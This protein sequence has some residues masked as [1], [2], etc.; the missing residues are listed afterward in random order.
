MRKKVTSL[1]FSIIILIS[2]CSPRYIDQPPA[3]DSL[4][5]AINVKDNK[6][7]KK[8]KEIWKVLVFSTITFMI[9]TMTE[10]NNIEYKPNGWNGK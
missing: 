2:S 6:R 10:H 4:F 3:P 7:P 1:L 8:D 5:D 9:Y